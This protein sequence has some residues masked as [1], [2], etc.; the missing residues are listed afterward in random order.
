MGLT[1]REK[2]AC[3]N[4]CRN[5][6]YEVT[7]GEISLDGEDLSEL[8]PEESNRSILSFNTC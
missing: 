4:H 1:V 6:N 5:E 3:V 2:Y 8:A 7:E